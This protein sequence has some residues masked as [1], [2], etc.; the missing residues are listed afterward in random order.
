MFPPCE[1]MS[2]EQQTVVDRYRELQATIDREGVAKSR[3]LSTGQRKALEIC[4]V[5]QRDDGYDKMY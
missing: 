4:P 1:Q 2:I 3:Q 5:A